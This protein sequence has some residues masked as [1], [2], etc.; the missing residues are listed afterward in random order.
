VRFDREQLA[1]LG[2]DETQISNVLRNKIRGDVATRFR[3]EDRQIDILVQANESDRQTIEDL[4][5][6]VVNSPVSADP[7]NSGAEVGDGEGSAGIVPIRLGAVASIS[8]GQGPSEINRVRSQ[9]AAIVSANLSGRALSS[10]SAE[11]E[12][13]LQELRAEISPNTSLALAGQNEEM[14]TSQ[15]SLIFAMCL[16]VF[17]VYLVMASQFESLVHP[18]VILFTVPLGLIGVVIALFLTQTTISVMVLLGVII[19]CGIVVNNAIVLIDYTN[20][21]RRDGMSVR[22]ALLQAGQVRLRPIIMTTLT[23]VLGLIPMA[24]S[25]GEGAEIR[26]P[27][28]VAVIGGLLFSTLLTLILIPVAY[29]LLNRRGIA[30]DPAFSTRSLGRPDKPGHGGLSPATGE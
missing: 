21:L 22:D 29:E 26:A 14:A 2:L 5:N 10:V 8:I 19:L 25:W 16:A 30:L 13:E 1:R 23:T 7:A 4:T 3:E 28:A 27:M 17:L 12:A 11:I 18:F 9:R 20:Q 6:L 24:V 15:R